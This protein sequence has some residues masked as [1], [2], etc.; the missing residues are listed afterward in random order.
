[1]ARMFGLKEAEPDAADHHRVVAEA[2]TQH[3]A[4]VDEPD[5]GRVDGHG[6]ARAQSLQRA[7]HEKLGS[8]QAQAQAS[9]NN[10]TPPK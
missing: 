10:S 7:R 9:V 1:M 6:R 4:W 3:S 8:D 2:A 5:E